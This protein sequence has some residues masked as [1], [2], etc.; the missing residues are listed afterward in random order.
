MLYLAGE[1]DQEE[2]HR[3]VHAAVQALWPNVSPPPEI[4]NFI[5]ISVMGK[6]GPLMQI[7]AAGNPV[8][9]PAY[10]W[11]CRTLSNL[12]DVD[13]LIIDPKSKF[14]G[15]VENDNTHCAAWVNCLESLVARFKITILFAHHES[16]ALAGSMSQA[17][18]R[19]GSWEF[20]WIDM[21]EDL[22]KVMWGLWQNRT[23]GEWVF[24]NPL[25]NDRYKD[26]FKLMRSIC[27]RAGLPQFGYHTIRHFVASY[28]VDKKRCPCR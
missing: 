28:L 25:T 8:N 6:L 18:S 19:G 13:V 9:A 17:S 24:V 14:Y 26:R 2:L 12:P 11:L 27:R 16:K 7:D 15:L 20:D 5:P 3:P 4:N 22:E 1:D 21:N 10:A 23:D